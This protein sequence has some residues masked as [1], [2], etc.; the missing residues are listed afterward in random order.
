MRMPSSRTSARRLLQLFGLY[1]LARLQ[2]HPGTGSLAAT[3]RKA[4]DALKA[5][6]GLSENGA[7]QQVIARAAF[8]FADL[9]LDNAVRAIAGAA[10]ADLGG[11]AEGPHWARLFHRMPGEVVRLP[12]AEEVEEVKRIESELASGETWKTAKSLLGALT[13]A[14]EATEKANAEYRAAVVASENADRKLAEAAE[15]WRREYRAVFGGLTERLPGDRSL[16]E[17]FFWQ[18]GSRP[19]ASPPSPSA[20]AIATPSTAAA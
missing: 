8:D 5:A 13:A 20:P 10:K 7:A 4:L 16:V 6:L 3:W 17:S 11:R 1:L 18:R 9:A 14:R 15:A 2:A 12:I 19:E